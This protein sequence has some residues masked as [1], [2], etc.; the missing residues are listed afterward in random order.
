MQCLEGVIKD[1]VSA[2]PPWIVASCCTH[3]HAGVCDPY[4]V[5]TSSCIHGHFSRGS[6]LLGALTQLAQRGACDVGVACRIA[7][8][9]G[10]FVRFHFGRAGC[11]LVALREL[12]IVNVAAVDALLTAAPRR[13]P[14][15]ASA[16]FGLPARRCM[17]IVQHGAVV[18]TLVHHRVRGKIQAVRDRKEFA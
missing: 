2:V 9:G 3:P 6:I 13:F 10:I 15:S 16:G 11:E 4:G 5:R 12:P 8:G 18:F 7:K 17:V 1:N 14:G